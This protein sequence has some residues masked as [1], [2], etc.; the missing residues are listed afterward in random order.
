MIPLIAIIGR[1]NVGKSTLFNALIKKRRA[2]VAKVPGTT[3]DHLTEQVNW[4]GQEFF[5]IDT[6]GLETQTRVLTKEEEFKL[7]VQ[8]QVHRVKDTA[9]LIIQVVD[10]QAD[11]TREDQK[12]AEIIRKTGKPFILVVNKADDPVLISASSNFYRLGKIDTLI[13]ASA[14]HKVGLDE[15]KASIAK[16]LKQQLGRK[17]A[18]KK[19]PS[20]A[21]QVAIVGRPNVGKSSL[22]NAILGRQQAI[23]SP[24]AGTTLDVNDTPFTYKDQAFNL[25][26]TAGI[27]KRGKIGRGIDT[28]SVTRALGAIA[29]ADI[30]IQVLDATEG[31]T[32]Q[33]LHITQFA[34]E[35]KTGLILAV[36]KWDLI[37]L[38]K[39]NQEM[40]V[41][42]LQNE[43]N[44]VPFASLVFT[45]ASKGTHCKQL[46]DLTMDIAQARQQK[47][48]EKELKHWLIATTLKH[49]PAARSRSKPMPRIYSVRQTGINPPSFTF[50]MK[51]NEYLHFTYPRYLE[52]RL[53]LKFGYLGT[54]IK[55]EFT[56]KGASH[57]H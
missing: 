47:I 44:F 20:K 23:V 4:A 26:D 38:A 14:L 1:P 10:A 3:R 41:S 52:K 22:L 51:H 56:E 31:I 13:A 9:D 35:A 25:L 7:S 33:D 34:Q 11:I 46:L 37:D 8:E 43:F 28:F 32:R 18:A 40:F 39:S 50:N 53:R 45:S 24:V 2:I 5:L 16:I 17:K 19:A 48:S 15:L 29:R 12:V 54:A 55:L 27:K 42:Q 6:A 30:V 49:P 57:K 21:I 36:N